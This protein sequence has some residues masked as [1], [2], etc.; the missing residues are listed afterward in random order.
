[1]WTCFNIQA[2]I[3]EETFTVQNMVR[4]NVE[5]QGTA[6]LLVY[7]LLQSVINLTGTPVYGFCSPLLQVSKPNHIKRQ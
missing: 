7:R 5:K 4:R 1:M 3:H 2:Q 6:A